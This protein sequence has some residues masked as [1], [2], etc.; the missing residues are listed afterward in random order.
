MS[1]RG[2][3]IERYFDDPKS[4]KSRKREKTKK[5]RRERRRAKEDPNCTDEYRKYDGWEY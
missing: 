3:Q 1:G 2:E 5:H 4:R